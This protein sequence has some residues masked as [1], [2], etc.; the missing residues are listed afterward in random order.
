MGERVSQRASDLAS[1]IRTV[2]G[3][4]KR[5]LREQAGE[6]ELSSSQASV[7]A[8][9]ERD[10]P[11]T[12][13]TLAK[14]ESMRPQ[15]MGALVATLEAAKL[16]TGAPDPDDG[17]QTIWSLTAPGRTLVRDRRAARQSW[18]AGALHAKFTTEEQARLAEAIALMKRLVE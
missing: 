1:D 12:V 18:L 11:A 16:I 3:Q 4:L 8:L 6:G 10:G 2:V 13:T 14:R 17:R 7:L 15:S 9:L 5:K